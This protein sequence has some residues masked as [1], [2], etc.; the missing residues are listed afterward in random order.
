MVTS[1]AFGK[2]HSRSSTAAVTHRPD[3]AELGVCPSVNTRG[4]AIE[5]GAALLVDPER[6]DPAIGVEGDDPVVVR[7]PTAR[8]V[9]V[10]RASSRK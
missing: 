3:G 1:C 6:D 5:L 7:E 8:S 2:L 10:E 4:T 9:R